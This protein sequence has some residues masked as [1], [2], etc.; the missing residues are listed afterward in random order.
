MSSEQFKD[1]VIT[2]KTQAD[3]VFE[4][5]T[6]LVTI[7]NSGTVLD[8][9][10]THFQISANTSANA[11][12]GALGIKMKTHINNAYED[13]PGTTTSIDLIGTNMVTLSVPNMFIYSLQFTPT[14]FDADK[15]YGIT[16]LQ[17]QM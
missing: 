15:T 4:V 9:S 17:G 8:M 5:L 1:V 3:G 6:D 10:S 2:G 11:T 12:A 16:I 14:A 7:E 13:L